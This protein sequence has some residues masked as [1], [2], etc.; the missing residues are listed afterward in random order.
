M[1]AFPL[2]YFDTVRPHSLYNIH[3]HALFNFRT[4]KIM[5]TC[6]LNTSNVMKG[7]LYYIKFM[8]LANRMKYFNSSLFLIALNTNAPF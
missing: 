2:P 3:V 4:I 7:K 1:A 6:R 8:K 5:Q